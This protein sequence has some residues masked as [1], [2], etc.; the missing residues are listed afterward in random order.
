M[1]EK[2]LK[3]VEGR[4]KI[5]GDIL[6]TLFLFSGALWFPELYAEYIGFVRTLGE[7]PVSQSM[8]EE[9]VNAL[10]EVGLVEVAEGIRGTSKPEGE[11]TYLISLRLNAGSRNLLSV[12]SRIS[13]YLSEWRKYF[14]K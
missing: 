1:I 3:A 2:F 4:E 12:D 10:K 11:K 13:T 5:A 6:R 14:G 9:A 8:I 7:E